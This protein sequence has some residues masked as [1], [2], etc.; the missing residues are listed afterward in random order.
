MM[1]RKVFSL[2][3]RD[4][5]GYA[6]ASEIQAIFETWLDIDRNGIIMPQEMY[7]ATG[8]LFGRFCEDAKSTSIKQSPVVSNAGLTGS[9][10]KEERSYLEQALK[11]DNPNSQT[12]QFGGQTEN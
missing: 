7:N 3:D 12:H 6:S 11:F 1:A 5:N 2:L 8:E 10:S 4:N 9:L